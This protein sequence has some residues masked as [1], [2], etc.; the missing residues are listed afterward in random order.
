MFQNSSYFVNGQE[1]NVF[2]MPLM[3]VLTIRI[4]F[5]DH[6]DYIFK[7]KVVTPVNTK[8]YR[9]KFEEI[10]LV[11]EQMK[12][13]K[14]FEKTLLKQ[15]KILNFRGVTKMGKSETVVAGS[16]SYKSVFQTIPMPQG[17][18]IYC[19][20]KDVNGATWS[21][22]KSTD[23]NVFLKHNIATLKIAYANQEF[24]VKDPNIG[25]IDDDSVRAKA[26]LDYLENPPFG[27]EVNTSKVTLANL[28]GANTPY[29]HVY[30]NL[31]NYGDRSRIIPYSN[32]D[33]S[34]LVKDADLNIELLFNSDGAATD[35]SYIIILFWDDINLSF[36]TKTRIFSSPH[37]RKK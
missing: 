27:V 5:H 30:L 33:G 10:C 37:L 3:D 9:F 17:I 26:L 18:F 24:F 19:V 35:V 23:S 7:R 15:H 32:P 13:Q 14:G 8:L 36:D 6:L 21:W 2:P 22:N 20:H 29:P 28:M 31:C 4:A 12:L 1:Q 16:S 11:T 34:I 25:N